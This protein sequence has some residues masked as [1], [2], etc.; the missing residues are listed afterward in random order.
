MKNI[1][2]QGWELC[3]EAQFLQGNR[4]R[5]SAYI[6]SPLRAECES[7]I[8]LNMRAARAYMFYATARLGCIARAPHAYLPML[9]CD[10]EKNERELALKFGLDLLGISDIMLVCGDCISEGM[11]GEIVRA[12]MSTHEIHVFHDKVYPAVR[13]IVEESGGNLQSVAFRREHPM[14]S[15]SAAE[16]CALAYARADRSVNEGV[17]RDALSI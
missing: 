9:L 11:K 2:S 4:F 6:C 16:I 17:A 1:Y 3:L 12:A 15:L 10:A 8:L 5:R 7:G 14:L 13:K